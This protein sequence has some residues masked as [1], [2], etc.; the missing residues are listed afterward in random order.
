ME[1][2]SAP[3]QTIAVLYSDYSDTMVTQMPFSNTLYITSKLKWYMK[4]DFQTNTFF[5][6]SIVV[7]YNIWIDG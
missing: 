6:H 5:Y 3:D 4:S 7:G 2:F 1:L